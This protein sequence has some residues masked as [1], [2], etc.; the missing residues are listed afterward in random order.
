MKKE[1][2]M[3]H[4]LLIVLLVAGL[5]AAIY[6]VQQKTNIFPKAYETQPNPIRNSTEAV[7][8]KPISLSGWCDGNVAHFDWQA[9]NSIPATYFVRYKKTAGVDSE[10]L[11]SIESEGG[12]N[13]PWYHFTAGYAQMYK[14]W[15]V[16]ACNQTG[17][18]NFAEGPE[19]WCPSKQEADPIGPA[20]LNVTTT[21]SGPDWSVDSDH[22]DIKIDG[23][24][25]AW[26]K[27]I[28]TR[29][30]ITDTTTG[31]STVVSSQ[32]GQQTQISIDLHGQISSPSGPLNLYP[33]GRVYEVAVFVSPEG[34]VAAVNSRLVQARATV[35]KECSFVVPA[36]ATPPTI[37]NV[38]PPPV[39]TN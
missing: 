25:T 26:D 5:A 31:Q 13:S 33:D 22:L 28:A 27:D 32:G 35:S 21:C 36:L 16:Y 11:P 8:G 15:R 24:V 20:S 9:G 6:M 34:P 17:C 30:M 18:S 23:Q 10:W 19:I 37:L 38:T 1:N 7:P 4:V 39:P 12:T 2:G 3:A 14:H 29:T